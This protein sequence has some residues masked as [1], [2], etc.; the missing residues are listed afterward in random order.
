MST[1]QPAM[2][3]ALM[4]TNSMTPRALDPEIDSHPGA[5]SV[6]KPCNRRKPGFIAS[7]ARRGV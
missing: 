1:M 5:T 4:R 3:M 2:K 7:K 6:H